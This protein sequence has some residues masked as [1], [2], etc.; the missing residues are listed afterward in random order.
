[1]SP[2]SYEASLAQVARVAQVIER[3]GQ[4][5]A[6][7]IERARNCVAMLGAEPTR[8]ELWLAVLDGL[9][10]APARRPLPE[11]KCELGSLVDAIVAV[12]V[13]AQLEAA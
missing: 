9:L 1:M 11:G 8:D 6:V 3:S 12:L 13:P 4:P 10:R 5:R 7:A 2:R